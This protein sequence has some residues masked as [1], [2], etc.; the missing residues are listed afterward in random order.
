MEIHSE[1]GNHHVE[2]S[3]LDLGGG[4]KMFQIFFILPQLGEMIQ[5]DEHIFQLGWW[6]TT[7]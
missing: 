7:N 2:G 3:I 5:F 1:L 4:F 6:K